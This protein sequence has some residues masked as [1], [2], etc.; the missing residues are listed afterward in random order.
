MKWL[1]VFAREP[2]AGSAKTRLKGALSDSRRL[3]LYKAFLED[4]RELAGR[5]RC[6]KKVLAYD[7]PGKAPRYLKK[8]FRGFRM[9]GQKG[10]SLGEKMHN[11]F[12]FAAGRGSLK[13]VLIGSDSPT[14]PVSYIDKAFRL[15]GSKDLV[16]G[17]S[18]DGGYYLIALKNPCEGL[19][20]RVRWGSGSVRTQT[21]RN[22]RALK[23]TV[24][25]LPLWYDVDDPPSLKRLSLDVR[26]GTRAEAT[27]LVLNRA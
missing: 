9:Y 25:L 21:L 24:S 17:P 10:S 12:R 20:T 2:E 15:L 26:K 6:G 11:A 3:D 1:I 19:F 8:V 16:L 27:R 4:T 22:A 5:V 14:L 7:S 18:A 13:T 23:K